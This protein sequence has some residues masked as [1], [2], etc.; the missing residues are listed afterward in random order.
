MALHIEDMSAELTVVDGDLPLSEAQVA[1]LVA[2]VVARLHELE[3]EHKEDRAARALT[4]SA[5]PPLGVRE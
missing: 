4:A 5:A 2:A 1:R 3:R